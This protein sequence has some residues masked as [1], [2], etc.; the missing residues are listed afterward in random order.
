M[1]TT[2]SIVAA[3]IVDSLHHPTQLFVAARAY[4]ESLRGLYEFPGGKVERHENESDALVR[5]I[6]E[7]LGITIT[8]GSTV[9]DQTH[10]VWPLDNGH[11]MKVWIVQVTSGQIRLGSSHMSGH[12]APLNNEILNLPWIEA[13]RPIV[14]ALLDSVLRSPE[15][16]CSTQHN[17]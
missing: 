13:D 1:T 11:S 5:E 10:T 7:E 8:L 9:T 16:H 3:A 14:H 4:P 2:A 15:K 6:H 12:W 17:P